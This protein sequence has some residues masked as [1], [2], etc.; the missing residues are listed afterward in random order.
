MEKMA[1]LLL[2]ISGL[3]AMPLSPV[4]SQKAVPVEDRRQGTEPSR[5]HLVDLRTGLVQ[6]HVSQ[7]QRRIR[8]FYVP[9]T[10]DQFRQGTQ[11]S[12]AT[13]V[14]LNTGLVINPIGEMK[15]SYAYVYVPSSLDKFR[16]GTQNSQA[17]LVHPVTGEILHVAGEMQRSYWLNDKSRQQPQA[18]A[19]EPACNGEVISGKCYLFFSSPQTFSE[20]E[21]ICRSVSPTG[22]LAS[23][24]SPQLHSQL[25]FMV[26]EANKGPT[27][28]WLGGVVQADSQQWTDG[29]S[30]TYSDWMPGQPKPE[31]H[32]KECLEMFK[33][34][35]RWWST[36]NCRSKRA[37]ICSYPAAA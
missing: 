19:L 12:Q 5:R 1:V 26:T 31:K 37:F 34:G 25:A 17:I 27:L 7:M 30:W 35:E 28:T 11:N 6:D 10:T 29:S 15:R 22:H 8:D 9:P 23:V 20:A 16:Q 36:A 2:V 4:Q 13:L 24:T 14:N 18:A 21:A 32:Q 3:H 33:I